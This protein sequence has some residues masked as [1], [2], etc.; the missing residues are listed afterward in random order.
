[1][2]TILAFAEYNFEPTAATTIA[3]VY[4]LEK[5]SDTS[6][7][8]VFGAGS[9]VVLVAEALHGAAGPKEGRFRFG[10]RA[11]ERVRMGERLDAL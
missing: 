8:G 1:M 3:I 10:I 11:G 9:A 5:C 4:T 2:E 6:Q 7:V